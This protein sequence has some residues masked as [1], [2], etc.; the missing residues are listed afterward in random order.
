MKPKINIG[1]KIIFKTA[2]KTIPNIE[3]FG[4]LS[5][6]TIGFV[7]IDISK[8]G[9][10]REV[11]PAKVFAYSSI[12]SVDPNAYISGSKNIWTNIVKI[13]PIRNRELTDVPTTALAFSGL[14]RPSSK[15]KFA[16]APIPIVRPIARH[17][18]VIGKAIFVAAFPKYPTP[19]PM[20]IWSTML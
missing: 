3:Y 19:W 14:P 13:I 7:L 9:I 1:F 18:V 12:S 11:I 2:P 17:I 6:R 15:L 5:E 10:P 16:A 4:L 20:N 8:N